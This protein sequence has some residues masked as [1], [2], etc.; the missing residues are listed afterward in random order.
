MILEDKYK[1]THQGIEIP[2]TEVGLESL[3]RALRDQNSYLESSQ[4][5]KDKYLGFAHSA[6]ESERISLRK[7]AV[8]KDAIDK[9]SI[10]NTP[11]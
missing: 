5:E 10:L 9:I 7:I 1:E 6:M 4:K 3:K 2:E 11:L 8:L